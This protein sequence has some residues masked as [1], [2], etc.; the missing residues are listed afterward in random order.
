M[1]HR[2]HRPLLAVSLGGSRVR[3]R[4]LYNPPTLK[5]HAPVTPWVP[6]DMTASD[7]PY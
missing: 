1:L 7:H 6:S 3:I 5:D 4:N 2:G